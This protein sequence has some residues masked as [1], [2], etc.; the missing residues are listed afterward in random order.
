MKSFFYQTHKKGGFTLVEL[1]IFMA[2]FSVVLVVLSSLF[3]ATVQQQ[4]ENQGISA[5]ETDSTFIISR[6]QYD[7]DRA[8]AVIEPANPGD[9]SDTLILEIAGQEHVYELSGE[10]LTLTTP[11]DTYQ[12][13]SPRSRVTSLS[14]TQIGNIDGNPTVQVQMAVTSV[15]ENATGAETATIDTIFGIR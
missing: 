11:A 14:F 2:L 8:A 6:M 10:I 1:L 3:A 12:M 4:L 15:A 7:F 5:T 13:I 9:T